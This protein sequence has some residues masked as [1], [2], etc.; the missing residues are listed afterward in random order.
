MHRFPQRLI[1]WFSSESGMVQTKQRQITF[2][3]GATDQVMPDQIENTALLTDQDRQRLLD[4]EGQATPL[5]NE[6]SVGKMNAEPYLNYLAFLSS[7]TAVYFT[8]PLG[9]GEGTTFKIF[10]T[11][12]VLEIILI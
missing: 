6:S 9:N 4:N 3:I 10:P 1:K 12:N 8:Y 7:Q 2:M 5:L 11:L